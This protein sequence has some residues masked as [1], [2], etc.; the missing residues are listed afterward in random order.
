MNF[1]DLA[2]IVVHHK[3]PESLVRTITCLLDQGVV[4]SQVV[5]VDNSGEGDAHSTLINSVHPDLN[6]IYRSNDGYGAA[7]NSGVEWHLQNTSSTYT[8]VSTH[9]SLPEAGAITLL[10]RTMDTE[11]NAAVA[12]PALVTGERSQ[13]VWSLGGYLSSF[14]GIPR[15]QGHGVDRSAVELTGV[16]AVQWV[17]GAFVLFRREVLEQC[18]IDERF[19]LYMEEADHHL[20]LGRRGWAVL[21]VADAVVWQSSAGTP[22]YYQARNIQLFQAKNGSRLQQ[23]LSTPFIVGK[24]LARETI[25]KRS[26]LETRALLKGLRDGSRHK[27]GGPDS[28]S[29]SGKTVCVVNPLGGALAHYTNA[30]CELL[31]QGGLEVQ[32]FD[33]GEPSLSG[34][35][36]L[37]WTINYLLT[38]RQASVPAPDEGNQTIIVTWPVFG[39]IDLLIVKL[40]SS[41]NAAIV[42]HDPKPLVRSV[43]SGRMSSQLMRL[44]P[45]RPRIIVHSQQARVSMESVG[46]GRNLE[47][48][49]HPMFRPA[50]RLPHPAR[51]PG[52]RVIRV[53]GQYKQDRDVNLLISLAAALGSGYVLEIVGRGWPQVPGWVV[54]ARFV[55]EQE[56][57]ALATTTDVIVIP[58]KRFYQSGIAVRAVEAGTP[59]VGRADTSLAD[60]F[61]KSSPLLV[62]DED[63]ESS[64]QILPWVESIKYAIEH[65]RGDTQLVG[66]EMYGRTVRE[67][68]QW[69]LANHKSSVRYTG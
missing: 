10:I 62:V 55:S 27:L 6:I 5:I 23:L 47:V 59:V 14:L 69:V 2:V 56:L 24:A 52:P 12:G 63:V 30:L 20:E 57:A 53:L 34:K 32:R 43:G 38:L 46:L 61:G 37:S 58:Y 17:D 67:W 39:F 19:F 64:A 49:M 21:V 36:R 25:K 4:P 65:G 50:T 60:F 35:G 16:R 29:G 11:P 3:S 66:E 15:H 54:D 26:L 45:N 1:F 7:V 40:L 44:I 8:L 41:E 42:Y 31:E 68:K 48:V 51:V 28:A 33:I 18:P 13:T 9:E 22:S